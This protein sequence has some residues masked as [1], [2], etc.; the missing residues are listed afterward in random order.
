MGAEH[1]HRLF[2][3]GHSR[4]HRADPAIKVLALL[5]FMVVVVSTP[6]GW[7]PVF[8]GY[9]A[10]L[11]VLVA[12]SRVPVGHLAPRMMVELP[13]VVFACLLPFVA[14]GP[15]VSVGPLNVS[16][17]GLVSAA[18]LLTK[19]TLGVLAA[20]LLAAT[21]EPVDLIRGLQR[22]RVPA[23]LVMI[24]TLMIRYLEVVSGELGRMLIAMRSRGCDPRSPRHW[25][26]LA[27]ALG[28]LF[29]RSYERGERVHLAMLSRGYTG[30]LP[31]LG[32]RR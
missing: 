13:F 23:M 16:G 17:P 18:A 8:A 9:Y 5:G 7:G 4:L 20:L 30:S 31:D 2:F 12:V 25:P 24:L 29:I 26:T 27:R 3:H 6:I 19:A 15:T 1:G 22:I 32:G 11:A 14:T 21:T 28:S 10:L